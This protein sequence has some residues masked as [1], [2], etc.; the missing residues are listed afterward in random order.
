MSYQSERRPGGNGAA[1][2]RLVIDDPIFNSFTDASQVDTCD[3]AWFA[4]TVDAIAN[5]KSVRLGVGAIEVKLCWLWF[6]QRK[7]MPAQ[8]RKFLAGGGFNLGGL[9]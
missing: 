4:K 9:Q 7:A 1:R 2:G 6:N 5:R 8:V 3:A